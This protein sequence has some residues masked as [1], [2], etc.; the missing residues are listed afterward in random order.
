MCIRDR[1]RA[2]PDKVAPGVAI[3]FGLFR[4]VVLD[5]PWNAGGRTVFEHMASEFRRI[6]AMP[7]GPAQDAA[8]EQ[9]RGAIYDRI[10]NTDPGP[11]FRAAL[12]R[13]MREAFGTVNDVGVFIR[14][15][16]NVEDLPGFTGAGLN[17]T[18]PNVVGLDNIIKSL[19]DV[20]ASP[21]TRRAFAWR[22]AHM[23][24]PEHVYPAVLL[25][26]TVPADF[27]GVMITADVDTGDRDFLSVAV[28]EGV[29][30]AVEGQ[31]AES[32]RINRKT[33]TAQLLAVASAP[34]RH[35]PNRKGGIDELP[36]SGREQLLGSNEIRQLIDI[37][38]E[39]PRKFPPITDD[40]GRPAPADVEFAF[41]DGR[42]QLLQ[43][44]PFLESRKARGSSYLQAMDKSV[45][46]RAT[47]AVKMNEV[48]AR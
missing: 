45:K 34:T 31:A 10:V 25:L 11:E 27:S 5:R 43:I 44:R 6:E 7:H 39:I 26:R 33:G 2:F 40:Q 28:N 20:W 14:S 46:Q 23:D 38:G 29:G 4:K 30:G 12:E 8:Y 41:L 48:P 36:A 37:S 18:V 13:N 19:K 17:L 16:T 1:R 22:N 3:P 15:D 35:V 9:L 32:L 24:G 42:L 21:Y 47:S